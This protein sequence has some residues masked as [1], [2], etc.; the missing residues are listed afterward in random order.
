MDHASD[1]P[2]LGPQATMMKSTLHTFDEIQIT[3]SET[4]NSRITLYTV[5]IRRRWKE[6]Q[7]QIKEREGELMTKRGTG[8]YTNTVILPVDLIFP[9]FYSE[10]FFASFQFVS[11]TLFLL[12]L[13]GYGQQGMCLLDAITIG[14]SGFNYPLYP[15]VY[16]EGTRKFPLLPG[17]ARQIMRHHVITGP[18]HTHPEPGQ[19]KN[20]SSTR[21]YGSKRR[22]IPPWTGRSSALTATCFN[23]AFRT[24]LLVLFPSESREARNLKQNVQKDCLSGSL[25]LF[26][27]FYFYVL[28]IQVVR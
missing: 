16:A 8:Q 25:S 10:Y 14:H 13:V 4:E 18:P 2:N 26:Q 28:Q 27:A 15:L 7:H 17:P 11:P 20:N 24:L 6:R 1:S 19:N 22:N 3:T 21:F 9:C 23:W 12:Q 5:G